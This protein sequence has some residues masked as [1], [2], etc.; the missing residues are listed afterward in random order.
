VD[1]S[2]HIEVKC[3]ERAQFHSRLRGRKGSGKS[4]LVHTLAQH[5]PWLF[6]FDVMG[7][8]KWVPNA[9]NDLDDVDDFLGW[10]STQ[11]TLA[12]RYVPQSHATEGLDLICE[13]IYD[14]GNT[15][16]IVE[17]IAM[18]CS[19]SFLP[20]ELDRIVRLG[21][22]QGVDFLWTCQ[23]MAEVARR[24]TAA[25]DSFIL[26]RHSEPRD[27]DAI[28]DRCGR[29]VAEKISRLGLHD[30]LVWGVIEGRETDLNECARELAAR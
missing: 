4:T 27:L 20:P 23:R 11:Q 16:F 19:P 5:A 13:W 22:H 10:A 18:L 24:L 2:L 9:F 6:V 21:R 14:L 12:G 29:D 15:L 28:A 7:E 26:F 8:H 3:N 1:S 17:E 25:T 30:Y